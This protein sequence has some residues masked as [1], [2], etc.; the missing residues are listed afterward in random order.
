MK[1]CELLV[2]DYLSFDIEVVLNENREILDTMIEYG[3]L[4]TLVD[5]FSNENDAGTLV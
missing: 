5:I 3:I 1:V 4:E 2:F